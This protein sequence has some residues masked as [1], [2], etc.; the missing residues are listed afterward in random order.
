MKE[1]RYKYHRDTGIPIHQYYFDNDEL[2]IE[3]YIEW[4]ENIIE[5]N[6]KD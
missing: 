2:E 4:L 5:A 6:E 3:E 1:L